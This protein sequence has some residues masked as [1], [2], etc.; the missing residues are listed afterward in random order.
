MW[1]ALFG[2]AGFDRFALCFFDVIFNVIWLVGGHYL[3]VV[4]WYSWA[5]YVE[6]VYCF[7]D[8]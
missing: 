3:L 4:D 2:C 7:D 1:I 6:L 5:G 8:V